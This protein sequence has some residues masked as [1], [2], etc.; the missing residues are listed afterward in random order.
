LRAVQALEGEIGL[1]CVGMQKKRRKD[2]TAAQMGRLR[3][4]GL[5]KEQ[6]SAIGRAAVNARWAKARAQNQTEE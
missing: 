5:T 2:L 3:W 6:R 1:F 4:K